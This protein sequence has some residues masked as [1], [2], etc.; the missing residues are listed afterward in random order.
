MRDIRIIPTVEIVVV[1]VGE[2]FVNAAMGDLV[3]GAGVGAIVGYAVG[4]RLI[5]AGLDAAVKL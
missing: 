5:T 1:S 4:E 2:D 3:L